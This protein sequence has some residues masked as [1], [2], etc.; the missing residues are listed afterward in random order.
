MRTWM[1]CAKVR[2]ERALAWWVV[3]AKSWNH[4]P[5]MSSWMCPWASELRLR[6][7]LAQS[8]ADAEREYSAHLRDTRT[9][10]RECLWRHKRAG[11]EWSGFR[12]RWA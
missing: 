4:E 11:L 9:D 3:S 7:K 12:T 2:M 10:K 6:D 5:P 8:R 1:A